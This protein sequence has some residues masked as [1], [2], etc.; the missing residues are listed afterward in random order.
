MV[1]KHFQISVQ[2]KRYQNQNDGI[3]IHTDMS[4]AGINASVIIS[5]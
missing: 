1:E 2:D 4:S 3:E 5:C